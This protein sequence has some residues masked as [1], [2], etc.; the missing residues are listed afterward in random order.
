MKVKSWMLIFGVTTA[1]SILVSIALEVFLILRHS[2]PQL[3]SALD[4]FA[5]FML[6]V[7]MIVAFFSAF[8]TAGL[9]FFYRNRIKESDTS[10][11][12]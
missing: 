8:I 7:M 12:I 10:L 5:G 2:E 9:R 11:D 6:P 4:R 1:F 3:D